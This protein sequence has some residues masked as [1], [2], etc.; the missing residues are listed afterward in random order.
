[1]KKILIILFFLGTIKGVAQIGV[2][3]PFPY[4]NYVDFA[5]AIATGLEAGAAK[6]LENLRNQTY[7]GW[8]KTGIGT[9]AEETARESLRDPVRRIHFIDYANM[10]D[11]YINGKKRKLCEAK[12]KYLKKSHDVVYNMLNTGTLND[13]R[14]GT[15]DQIWEKYASI[16]NIITQELEAVKR[17]TE[18]RQKLKYLK[19]FVK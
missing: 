4:I 9:L 8:Q 19:Y 11:V 16:C 13:V 6:S 2:P 15:Q 5:N 10:C 17:S 3:I 18:K 1:M 7:K 14:K 12:I